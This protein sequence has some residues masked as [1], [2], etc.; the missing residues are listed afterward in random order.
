MSKIMPAGNLEDI[1][2]RLNGCRSLVDMLD[3][4]VRRR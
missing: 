1:M 4:L 3:Y 2:N